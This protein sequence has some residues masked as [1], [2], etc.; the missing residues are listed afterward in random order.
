MTTIP[1]RLAQT[2]HISRTLEEARKRSTALY[3]NFY[4]SVRSS[5][6]LSRRLV[7][8]LICD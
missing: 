6:P 4:R 5:T 3:R 2:S 1:S 8:E 7:R